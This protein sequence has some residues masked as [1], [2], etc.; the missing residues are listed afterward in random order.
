MHFAEWGIR[1]L[2][3]PGACMACLLVTLIVAEEPRSSGRFASDLF[4]KSVVSVVS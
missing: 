1:L 4:H 3:T 2:A